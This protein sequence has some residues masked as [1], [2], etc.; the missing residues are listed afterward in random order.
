M[1]VVSCYR[2]T[3]GR[4]LRDVSV[5]KAVADFKNRLSS[6]QTVGY[7]LERAAATLEKQAPTVLAPS[8]QHQ[9]PRRQPACHVQRT[10][11]SI[12]A[13]ILGCSAA[14]RDRLDKSLFRV[15]KFTHKIPLA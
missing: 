14:E 15:A 1:E 13:A 2:N 4:F 3:N 11:V 12:V 8:S 6:P 10:S 7:P 9:H 5:M